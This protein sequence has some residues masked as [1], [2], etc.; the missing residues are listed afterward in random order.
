M[1]VCAHSNLSETRYSVPRK[2]AYRHTGSNHLY[3]PTSPTTCI[4]IC[5]CL[6]LIAL[7][8]ACTSID[9]LKST[10]PYTPK[11]TREGTVNVATHASGLT[12]D[13]VGETT[14]LTFGVGSIKV[15]GDS[16]G[17]IMRSVESALDAAGYNSQTDPKFASSDA[18]YIKAH[19][20]KIK[21]GNFFGLS[22]GTI[23]I[24][25]RLET[26]D[27]ALLWD[28]RISSSVKRFSSYDHTA[29][30]AMNRL[31]KYMAKAFVEE[32]FFTATQR[33]KRHNEFLNENTAIR[34]GDTSTDAK[35]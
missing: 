14:V 11:N 30:V 3:Q 35:Y 24:H 2:V 29:I 8:T 26:R 10:K 20:E 17:N 32:D 5:F 4:K 1:I 7:L 18:A 13:K 22:W 9:E 27:G 33:I 12:S 19:V 25:L 23:S 16:A 31:V 15:H 6:A 28:A 21:F 34:K